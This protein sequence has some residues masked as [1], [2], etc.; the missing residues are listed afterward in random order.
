MVEPPG[1]DRS[2]AHT[3]EPGGGDSAA[4]TGA[5]PDTDT[6]EDTAVDPSM[7]VLYAIRHAEKES[8]GDDPPLTEEGMARAEALAARMTDV[9]LSAVYATDLLRTQQ[10]VAPT[11][12]AHGLPVRIDV[13][14]EEDLAALILSDHL[15]DTL[16][17]SGHSYTIPSLFL[18]L[19]AEE[20]DVDGYGQLWI[21]TGDATGALT[22]VE[23]FVGEPEE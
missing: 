22:V 1:V 11:A 4:H 21:L 10:T 20:P 15:G 9:P 16:L 12:E 19:H 2:V 7:W 13:D 23:E 17:H 6:A 18:A 14:S 8:E 3:G 5:P